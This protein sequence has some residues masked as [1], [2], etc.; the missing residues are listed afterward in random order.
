MD[1]TAADEEE[2]EPGLDWLPK[3]KRFNDEGKDA[4]QGRLAREM[5]AADPPPMGAYFTPDET[6]GQR[7]ST[8]A[9][10]SLI[11]P[12]D[13]IEGLLAAQMAAVHSASMESFRRAAG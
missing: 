2:I 4:L 8:L 3:N 11:N 10:L 7:A 1:E 12:T 13:V 9:I 6:L 5:I